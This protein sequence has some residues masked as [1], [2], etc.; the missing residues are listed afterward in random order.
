MTDLGTQLVVPNDYIFNSNYYYW[1]TI[2]KNIEV[3]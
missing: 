1:Y 3:F 2:S